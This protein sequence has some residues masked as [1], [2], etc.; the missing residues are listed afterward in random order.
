MRAP[1]P[2]KVTR[3]CLSSAARIKLRFSSSILL[4]KP[5]GSQTLFPNSAETPGNAATSA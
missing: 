5:S 3:A 1:K 4:D 2:N